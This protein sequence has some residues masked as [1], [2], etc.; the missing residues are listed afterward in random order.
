MLKGIPNK[1]YARE[2]KKLAVEM[3]HKEKLSYYETDRCLDMKEN[4]FV[5][6]LFWHTENKSLKDKMSDD[7]KKLSLGW[8]AF[9]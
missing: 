1:R 6:E 8:I 2:F 4:A 3:M 5:E 9:H 7:Q